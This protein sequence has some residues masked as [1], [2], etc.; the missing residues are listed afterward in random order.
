MLTS[1]AAG[2]IT[3]GGDLPVNRLGFGAMRLRGGPTS[4]DR[5]TSAAVAR[6]AV[7]LGVSF[8]DTAD[9]YDLGDN[10]AL[11]AE[12]LHPYPD[13]L[14]IATKAGQCHPGDDWI[15]LGRPEYLRQ[16]A[17]L[18][19]RR[20]RVERIDLF[21]LHRI[22]PTVPLADQ[23]GALRR[24]QDEGKVRHVGL[25]EVTVAQITE[26]EKITP[27]VS[28]QN[29]YNL[30]DRG[31]EAVLDHCER[32][33]IAFIPWLPVARARTGAAGPA[34]PI[35]TVAGRL[36]ATRTQ[37]AL[38]WLLHRS[39]VML[40]IPGTSSRAHLEEN[41]AAASLRLTPDDVADLDALGPSAP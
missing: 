10:E 37:V 17:E 38:A 1:D 9:S 36:G 19:L 24:L 31:S 34:D 8:I 29:R 15:P 25:S 32:E 18:S 3:I 23:I 39:P 26:A 21:Q 16:Q 5:A 7:E 30:T 20:L 22:D 12:A 28:V 4:Q 6:R 14:V 27:I 11:L 40:P 13:G 41:M 33:G 35:G 2:T